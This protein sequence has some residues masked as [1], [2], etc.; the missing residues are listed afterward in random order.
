MRLRD[1]SR[2]SRIAED[3]IGPC[4]RPTR[5]SG[6]LHKGYLTL[7]CA[8]KCS[9]AARVIARDPENP[10]GDGVMGGPYGNRTGGSGGTPITGTPGT[11]I[12]SYITGKGS[13]RTLL[14]CG[15]VYISVYIPSK[16][17]EATH[18]FLSP[19]LRDR[20]ERGARG[21]SAEKGSV[22]RIYIY[23]R[24]KIPLSPSRRNTSTTHR[25]L[26][27]LSPYDLYVRAIDITHLIENDDF[28]ADIIAR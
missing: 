21:K 14:F 6:G 18:A 20:T 15:Y 24:N 23:I 22:S 10:E 9:T 11:F 17:S 28:N 8:K 7:R 16:Q 1:L 19:T 26:S 13:R 5:E 4:W 25:G 2:R 27:F 12:G 3:V